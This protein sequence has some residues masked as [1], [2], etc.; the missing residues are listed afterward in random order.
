MLLCLCLCCGGALGEVVPDATPAPDDCVYGVR[1]DMTLGNLV[2]RTTSMYIVCGLA[3]AGVTLA[4]GCV[5]YLVFSL[6][7]FAFAAAAGAMAADVIARRWQTWRYFGPGPAFVGGV[8]GNRFVFVTHAVRAASNKALHLLATLVLA[9]YAFLKEENRIPRWLTA[10][11]CVLGVLCALGMSALTSWW[12]F[13]QGVPSVYRGADALNGVSCSGP[14]AWGQLAGYVRFT[15]IAGFLLPVVYV[16]S[17]WGLPLVLCVIVCSAV[18]IARE[19]NRY[20]QVSAVANVINYLLV[21]IAVVMG[22]RR[23]TDE[24]QNAI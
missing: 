24:V 16:L 4:G 8:T 1:D 2:A 10:L 21:A 17:Y 3:F 18:T 5:A 9:R 22:R 23:K 11:R 14:A 13:T 15:V 12:A 6:P 20:H 19:W 7:G